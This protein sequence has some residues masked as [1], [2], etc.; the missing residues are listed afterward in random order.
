MLT[1]SSNTVLEPITTAMLRG[2]ADVSVHFARFT[3]TEI[4]LERRALSQ[5]DEAPMLAAAQLLADARVD[6]IAWNGTSAAW[7]GF[8]SDQALCRKIEAA[9]GIPAVTCVL[10]LVELLRRT[11]IT[12]LGLVTPYIP[13]VQQQ[14]IATFAAAGIDVVAER[15]SSVTNNFSFAEIEGPRIEG[16]IREVAAARPEAI[17]TLCTN[18][19]GAPL[20]DGLERELKLPILD[21]VAVVLWKALDVTG[22]DTRA[23]T[24]WGRLFG[25]LELVGD[26][27]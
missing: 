20:V 1:P 16:M 8:E 11:A 24:G 2:V 23:V 25:G 22:I 10:S 15:H 13:A 12:R 18:L 3:V 6:V 19:A 7:L 26:A 17:T 27:A 14:I 5:F 4:S 21:S 9:T